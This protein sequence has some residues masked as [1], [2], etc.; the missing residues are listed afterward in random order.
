[1]SPGKARD[2]V[3][4]K[5]VAKMWTDLGSEERDIWNDRAQQDNDKERSEE[6]KA[7]TVDF[8]KRK[9]KRMMQKA[10]SCRRLWY[11]STSCG[12]IAIN[13]ENFSFECIAINYEIA[14]L[15]DNVV[16]S[17]VD[18]LDSS[19]SSTNLI[20][21]SSLNRDIFLSIGWEYSDQGLKGFS[22]CYDRLNNAISVWCS[23]HLGD[24]RWKSMN[25]IIVWLHTTSFG[26]EFKWLMTLC[27]KN[28]S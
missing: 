2:S 1:M 23:Q 24:M 16:R 17:A 18:Y 4:M 27:V 10:V 25:F 8:Q 13:L 6:E 3:Q 11:F 9:Y 20:Y 5:A 26:N 14:L 21:W 15:V 12:C 22:F 19:C 7:A 28:V